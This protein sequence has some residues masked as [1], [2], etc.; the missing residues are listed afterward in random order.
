MKPANILHVVPMFDLREH[1]SSWA[2]WCKPTE[3]EENPGLW[4]HHALD[5]REK[6]ETGE[7]K[8]Q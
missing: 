1:E 8:L 6:Y 2:C 7:L 5:G 4:V 3:D